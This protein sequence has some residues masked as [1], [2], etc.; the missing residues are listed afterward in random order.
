MIEQEAI[1]LSLFIV[2][3]FMFLF[4]G[5]GWWWTRK[6][7]STIILSPYT[8]L[9]VCL[10]SALS[11]DYKKRV[12]QFLKDLGDYDNRIFLFSRAVFCR[13]TGRIFQDCITWYGKIH[14]DWSFLSRRY[15]GNYVSWGSL[16]NETKQEI[17]EAHT[18]LEG[19][20]TDFSC[21]NPSPKEVELQYAY[22]KPGP[23]YVDLNTFILLGWKIIPDTELEI[24]I[25]QKP[26]KKIQ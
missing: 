7:K 5:I 20:Q 26:F 18:S 13:D 19:F 8:Q 22:T 3:A 9:P 16:S 17:R 25:V 24:L 4:I 10:A 11:Y 12:G 15:P 1:L 21:P 6:K 14:L 2:F 23:L